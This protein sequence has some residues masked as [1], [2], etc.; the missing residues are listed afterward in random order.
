MSDSQTIEDPR[1][2]FGLIHEVFQ[3]LERHGYRAPDVGRRRN[4]AIGSAIMSLRQV[5]ED[6]QGYNSDENAP[7]DGDNA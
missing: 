1:F 3:A 2:T 7:G 6:Y 5:V 4:H